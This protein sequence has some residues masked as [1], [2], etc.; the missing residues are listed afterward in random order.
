MLCPVATIGERTNTNF[1]VGPTS[2]LE[3]AT[4]DYGGLTSASLARTARASPEALGRAVPED[5][6]RKITEQG[7]ARSLQELPGQDNALDLVGA[8]IDLGDLG[9][10]H[11]PLDRIVVDVAV[12]AEQ[13]HGIGG[14]V[15]RRV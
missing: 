6:P 13:L 1:R 8:L 15:H 14:D 5:R 10:A 7:A 12:P 9:V 2:G 3:Q 11:H 4:L